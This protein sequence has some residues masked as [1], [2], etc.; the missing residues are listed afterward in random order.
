MQ[1]PKQN[2]GVDFSNFFKQ[3]QNLP[4]RNQQ[5][6]RPTSGNKSPFKRYLAIALS[7]M[8]FGGSIYLLYNLY[9][10]SIQPTAN[11]QAPPGYRIS[12]TGN[13]PPKLIKVK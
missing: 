4:A 9:Q 3:R 13:E 2:E 1:E 8:S 6:G 11:Y 5:S 7:V 12:N 10:Q